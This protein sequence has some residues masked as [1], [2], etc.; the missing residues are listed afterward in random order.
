MQRVP[1]QGWQSSALRVT[2]VFEHCV[3][4]YCTVHFCAHVQVSVIGIATRPRDGILRN[5]GSIQGTGKIFFSPPK[6]QGCLWD[7]PGL[8]FSSQRVLLVYLLW[9]QTVIKLYRTVRSYEEESLDSFDKE[10]MTCFSLLILFSLLF[11]ISYRI[12]FVLFLWIFDANKC[13][14]YSPSFLTK[15]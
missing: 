13:M 7:Q 1:L 3:C 8:I 11:V 4:G 15:N 6:R 12:L 10:L 14:Y 2:N 9:L 5:C